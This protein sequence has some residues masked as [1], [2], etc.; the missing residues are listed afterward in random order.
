MDLSGRVISHYRILQKLGGGGMGIVYEAE[1]VRLGRRVALKFLPDGYLRDP[2]AA[3]RFQREARAASSLNHPHICT[4][5]D[6]GEEDEQHF[7]VMELLEGKTLK[8]LIAG[9]PLPIEQLIELG[10]EI[11]DALDAAH[12]KG[13]IHRDIKPANLFVTTRGHAKILDFGLAKVSPVASAGSA[14]TALATVRD[15]HD[16]LTNSGVT[17]GTIGYMSPEQVRGEEVDARSDIFSLGIVLYEMATGRQ[18]FT[19]TTSGL[20]FD[21]ILNRAP[22]SPVR[23]NPD[24]PEDI[25]RVI[26]TALEK[27]R[28]LRYQN[29]ADL[30]ADLRRLRRDISAR[31]H[32][33]AAVGSSAARGLPSAAGDMRPA[34]ARRRLGRSSMIAIVVAAVGAIAATIALVN[35][36]R[37]PALSDRDTLLVADFANTTGDDVFDGALRQALA[38]NLEQSPFLSI[39]SREELQDTLRLMKKSPEERVVGGV[40]RDACQRVGAAAMVEGS[41]APLGSHYAIALTALNCQSGKTIEGVQAEAADREHV[42]ASLSGAASGLRKRLGESLPTIERF[43]IPIEK[44]T[45]SSLEALKAFGVGEDMR[46]RRTEFGAVPFYQRAIELD[47]EFAMA[48]ARLSTIYGTMGQ[49][50]EMRRTTQEAYARRERVSERERFYIDGR[51]CNIS[52]DPDC[53]LNVYEIWVRTYPR[54]GIAHYGLSQ[55]YVQVGL[56]EK[57]IEHARIALRLDPDFAQPYA[58]VAAADLCAGKVSDARRTLDEAL[59]RHLDAPFVYLPRFG[60]AFMER[61]QRAMMMVRQWAAGR[62]EEFVITELDAE[63]AA[64]DGQMRRSHELSARA[65]QLA[66]GARVDERALA[67]RARGALYDAAAGDIGRARAI[68]KSMVPASP[69]ASVATFLLVAAVLARDFQTADALLRRSQAAGLGPSGL[70]RQLA[71]VLRDVDTGNRAAIDRMPPATMRDVHPLY[72]PVAYL[73]GLIYLHAQEGTK[74][75]AEFQR[76]LDHRGVAP[77]VPF[78]PLAIVQQARAF[79]LIGDRAKARKAYESFLALWKDAD[80]DIPIL[81]EARDEYARLGRT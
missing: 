48:Y 51:Q 58:G 66:A 37:A 13:I 2:R 64:F 12:A 62:P 67:V 11:A 43:S 14:D 78:Y 61:D 35:A 68:L 53:Y 6:I 56:C 33:V 18:P 30:E 24:V 19:G 42:L 32:A 77:T 75:A 40:A 46:A 49:F 25:E 29:A 10:V 76:I 65:E 54:D 5:H 60:V 80:P 44:A 27:D 1:D 17:V 8:H 69:P 55:S 70:R 9:R 34:T 22:T 57:A 73:R 31:T 15:P 20:I 26:H 79:A 3:E 45:T 72:R 63:A 21:A 7:I 16:S 81:R 47:P 59:T 23:L 36:K 39:V 28:T 50:A 52:P 74:A 71:E 41:I 4:I 38:I